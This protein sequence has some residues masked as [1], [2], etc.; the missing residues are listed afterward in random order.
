MACRSNGK[1]FGP[2]RRRNNEVSEL[3]AGPCQTPIGVHLRH[4]PP[5]RHPSLH[6]CTPPCLQDGTGLPPIPYY[7]PPLESGPRS[8]I[9]INSPLPPSLIRKSHIF[10]NNLFTASSLDLTFTQ[11]GR[12]QL[13][14]LKSLYCKE[15]FDSFE[16]ICLSNDLSRRFYATV[17]KHCS[18][19]SLS[20]LLRQ[21]G[22]K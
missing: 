22:K 8:E 14:C 16:N 18:L 6:W 19:L 2:L 9:I 5:T 20:S 10:T 21:H 11:W 7:C 12:K 15:G 4:T 1:Y 17:S 3:R 13:S